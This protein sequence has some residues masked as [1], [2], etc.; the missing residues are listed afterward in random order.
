M[1]LYTAAFPSDIAKPST[2]VR[3]TKTGS[4]MVMLNAM[5]P[6]TPWTT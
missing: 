6:S 5:G 1:C 4:E 2:T 3:E